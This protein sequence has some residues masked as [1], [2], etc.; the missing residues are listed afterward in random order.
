MTAC[1][2]GSQFAF[3]RH[4]VIRFNWNERLSCIPLSPG[5]RQKST[6]DP[7][8]A[9]EQLSGGVIIKKKKYSRLEV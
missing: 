9:V 1:D 3:T 8:A 4:T 7:H 6:I 5:K 2:Q